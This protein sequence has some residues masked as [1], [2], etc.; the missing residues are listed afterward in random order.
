MTFPPTP[1]HLLRTFLLEFP[2]E[3][4]AHE[5]AV[6]ASEETRPALDDGSPEPSGSGVGGGSGGG[7]HV[8][9]CVCI[10]TSLTLPHLPL[11]PLRLG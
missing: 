2:G 1:P 5:G 11:E 6:P 4:G 3:A 8:C 10:C 9:L 7:S